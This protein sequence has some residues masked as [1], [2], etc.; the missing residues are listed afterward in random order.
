MTG[1]Q[2]GVEGVLKALIPGIMRIGPRYRLVINV[3][4]KNM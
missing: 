4:V 1:R 2:L 3:S